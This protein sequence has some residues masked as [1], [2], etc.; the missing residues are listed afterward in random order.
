M[1]ITLLDS[2]TF[3]GYTASYNC[4]SGDNRVLVVTMSSPSVVT[5]WSPT[6]TFNG[7]AMTTEVTDSSGYNFSPYNYCSVAIFTL[8]N[9]DVGS[10]TL[11]ISNGGSG[12]VSV[13]VFGGTSQLTPAL[14]ISNTSLAQFAP[15]DTVGQALWLMNFDNSTTPNVNINVY[16]VNDYGTTG[17]WTANRVDTY[18]TKVG[19]Y[20]AYRIQETYNPQQ[21]IWYLDNSWWWNNVPK[22]TMCGIY[23][24][25]DPS[26]S[27]S[28]TFS[29]GDIGS[30]VKGLLIQVADSI[31]GSDTLTF[32]RRIIL[33]LTD[34]FVIKNRGWFGRVT[35]FINQV[36]HSSVWT[37]KNKN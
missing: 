28:D 4:P 29:I 25:Q 20:S 11:A 37:N 18:H 36:K 31:T 19:N 21:S 5:E 7:V 2:T 35:N 9:P 23:L 27:V 33:N 1:A 24:K 22:Y 6:A 13:M 26:F 16:N 3:E 32:I 15:K 8:V 12:H 30:A 10:Y 17:E 14:A 34:T